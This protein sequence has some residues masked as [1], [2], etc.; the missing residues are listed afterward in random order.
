M[1]WGA[2]LPVYVAML[3]TTA[4]GVRLLWLADP[5]LTNRVLLWAIWAGSTVLF[6]LAWITNEAAS[7]LLPGRDGLQNAFRLVYTVVGLACGLSTWLT[8]FPPRAYTHW[9]RDRASVG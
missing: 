5:V 2:L 8:F 1:S 9:V 6:M 7:T 3:V 4:L